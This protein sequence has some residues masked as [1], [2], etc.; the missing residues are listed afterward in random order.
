MNKYHFIKDEMLVH[1][2]V[3]THKDPKKVI[4]VGGCENIKEELRK[5]NIFTETLFIDSNKAIEEFKRYNGTR[6]YD[7]AIVATSKFAK[8]REFWIE[9]TKLLDARAV[10]SS[11]ISNIITQEEAAKEE[12]K[13]AGAIYQI[14]MPYRYEEEDDDGKLVNKYLLLSSRFYHP[15]ADINLQRADLTDGFRYYNSDIAKAA[16]IVPTFV[17]KNYLG[18]I[19][20]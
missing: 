6:D 7:I 8:N 19:K 20:R 5:Y 9:L 15:T 2:P 18:I 13:V 14:V 16:F 1:V 4:I 11:V 17:Y 3:C 10:V 12:L